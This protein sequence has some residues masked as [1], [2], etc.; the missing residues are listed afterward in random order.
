MSQKLV[1]LFQITSTAIQKAIEG[2]EIKFIQKN[3]IQKNAGGVGVC[4]SCV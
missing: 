1:N 2:G 3:A 4:F